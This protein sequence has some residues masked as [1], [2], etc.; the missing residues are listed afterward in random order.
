MEKIVD[1]VQSRETMLDAEVTI[2]FVLENVC[3]MSD[4]DEDNEEDHFA[5]LVMDRIENDD[6]QLDFAND[7]AFVSGISKMS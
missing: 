1:Q 6:Y 5:E 2:T 7:L 4:L 3:Y